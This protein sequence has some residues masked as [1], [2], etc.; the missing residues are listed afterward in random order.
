MTPQQQAEDALQRIW[1]YPSFR[2]PQGEIIQALLDGHDALIVMPTGGGKS[3]CFQI[4]ALLQ[5]GVTLIVSPLVAL[6]E[7]QVQELKLRGLSAALLHSA[8]PNHERRQTLQRISQNRLRLL[9]LSPET[10]LS[11]KV[12]ETLC[13]PQVQVNGLVLDEAHCLVQW[14][15]TFRPAYRRLGAVRAALLKTKSAGTRIAI[16]AFTATANPDAQAT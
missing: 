9:Y 2:P 13:Q 1:G 14:G 8:V 12:W 5:Q 3:L 11:P 7:N 15:D 10:L 16:A 4:P 6:I